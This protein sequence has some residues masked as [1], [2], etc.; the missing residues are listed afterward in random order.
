MCRISKHLSTLASRHQLGVVVWVLVSVVVA[1]PSSHAQDQ[2]S[3]DSGKPIAHEA[4]KNT[5]EPIFRVSKTT[6][7]DP[8]NATAVTALATD[9]AA[10]P[11]TVNP[12][13]IDP[14]A[15]M[16]LNPTN[17]DGASD[18]AVLENPAAIPNAMGATGTVDASTGTTVAAHPL[19]R[20]LDTAKSALAD[21]RANV[22]DYT[23]IMVKRER[24]G[25]QI[26]DPE[27]MQIKVRCPRQTETLNA[28]FSIY[29]K[30]LRPKPCAGREVI[31][32]DGVNDSKI[33]VHE[34]K[35]LMSLKTLNLDPTG[36]IAMKG[37]RYPIYEAGLENLI[38]KL[39]EKAERDRQ[40]GPCEVIY[41][42]NGEVLN[43]PCDVIE[44][45]H[46]ERRA[47]Y[48]FHKAQ[49]FID[50]E[51][52][53]PIRYAAYGWPSAPGEEPQLNEEY[54]Y[55]NIRLNV[56]YTDDDFSPS[57]SAYNYPPR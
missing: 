17:P 14:A 39:I 29:M 13:V 15:V 33:C 57:N 47:P 28:P 25:D 24:V 4:R 8:A 23:A 32:V 52:G 46:A 55:A 6:N 38:Q 30:F 9:P 19:D 56:G 40:A 37:N 16:P 31:W 43:R 51:L 44:V 7:L 45:I 21:M 2:Q 18:S 53:L 48:D 1:C 26:S 36:W 3:D 42:D 50:K 35:G 20:A 12:V 11:S 34:G 41:R 27:L 22:F 5:K 10:Q 54:T 49:V